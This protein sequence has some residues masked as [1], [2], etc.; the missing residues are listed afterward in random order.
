MERR[1]THQ[2]YLQRMMAANGMILMGD[3]RFPEGHEVLEQLRME[4][5]RRILEA[6]K[7]TTRYVKEQDLIKIEDTLLEDEEKG[8]KENPDTI[9]STAQGP[10]DL[11]AC[12]L[13][14]ENCAACV[15]MGESTVLQLGDVPN[16]NRQVPGACAICLCPYEAHDSVCNSPNEHCIHAFHTECAVTWLSKKDQTLCPCCRQDFCTIEPIR[17]LQIEPHELTNGTP[18]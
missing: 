1:L 5:S 9:E 11:G 17:A 4:R 7:P 13:D 10:P 16:G 14:D 8:E 12:A 18:F 3:H 2:A 6:L 15:G